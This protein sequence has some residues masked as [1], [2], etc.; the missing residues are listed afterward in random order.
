MVV[1]A[2]VAFYLKM[3][4][5]TCFGS[6]GREPPSSPCVVAAGGLEVMSSA[7]DDIIARGEGQGHRGSTERG[8]SAG[9]PGN[10]ASPHCTAPAT[11]SRTR[12]AA[13]AS[14]SASFRSR[15]HAVP[16]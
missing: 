14:A 7:L 12:R 3:V 5:F 13:P 9:A 4:H 1:A 15:A 6:K 11:S 2:F 16:G 8:R 10:D